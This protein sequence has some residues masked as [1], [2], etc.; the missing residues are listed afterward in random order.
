[1][2]L[3]CVGVWSVYLDVRVQRVFVRAVHLDFLGQLKFRLE[4]SSRSNI[5]Q[6]IQ[7]L[8]SVRARLLLRINKYAQVSIIEY[9]L[10]TKRIHSCKPPTTTFTHLLAK[11]TALI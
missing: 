6:H 8:S 5:A 1:M 3:K 2:Y 10:S 9:S 7:D 11:Q 4:V